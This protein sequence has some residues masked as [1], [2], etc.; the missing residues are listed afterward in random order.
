MIKGFKYVG[1]AILGYKLAPVSDYGVKNASNLKVGKGKNNRQEVKG[2]NY[3]CDRN[4]R[5][6]IYRKYNKKYRKAENED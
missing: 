5:K 4:L 6:V 1:S 2:T 3:N